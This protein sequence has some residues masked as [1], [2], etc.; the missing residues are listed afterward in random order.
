ME[1]M[2]TVGCDP[3]AAGQDPV[4]VRTIE[5]R[6][7]ARDR[8]FPCEIWYPAAADPR[9]AARGVDAFAHP[10][11]SPTQAGRSDGGPA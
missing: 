11:I 6:D 8:V 1:D 10:G 5:A 2:G 3:F 7:F 4:G 9:V